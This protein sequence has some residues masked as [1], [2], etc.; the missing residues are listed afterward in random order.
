MVL[1]FDEVITGFRVGFG[2]A[3]ERYGVTPDLVVLAK[4][5]A[6]GYPLSAVV[7]RADLID[8]SLH[9]VV[10][11]GTYNGN[12]IVLPAHAAIT[13][14]ARLASTGTS[15]GAAARSPTDARRCSATGSPAPSIT[16][17]PSSSSPSAP[18]R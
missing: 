10:H 15:S 16:S 2:G 9:G 4:A 14:L 7:G 1:I 5:V 3:G 11:A 6:A 8:Q 13:A 12:P 18:L 17:A